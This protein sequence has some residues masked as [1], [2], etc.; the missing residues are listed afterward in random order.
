MESAV[1]YGTEALTAT[2]DL[3]LDVIKLGVDIAAD[4][5]VDLA[6]VGRVMGAAPVL[7]GETM[8]VAQKGG[9]L[10]LELKDLDAEE[11]AACVAHVVAKLAVGDEH[12]KRIVDKAFKAAFAVYDLGREVLAARA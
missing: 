2:L 1:K 6:D 3:G 5:K 7:I 4:K 10:A 11:A 9:E 12:A 8:A